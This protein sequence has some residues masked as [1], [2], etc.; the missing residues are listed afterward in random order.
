MA[1]KTKKELIEEEAGGL[2]EEITREGDGG[3]SATITVTV[4]PPQKKVSFST[5]ASIANIPETHKA[6]MFAFVAHP[7]LK[8]TLDNWYLVFSSY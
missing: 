7:E 2:V 1:R 5:W 4:L 3:T 6:G 8:R